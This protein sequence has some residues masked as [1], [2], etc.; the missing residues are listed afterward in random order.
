MDNLEQQVSFLSAPTHLAAKVVLALQLLHLCK[1]LLS[2][3]VPVAALSALVGAV[4]L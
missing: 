3:A 1:V 2:A 4:A